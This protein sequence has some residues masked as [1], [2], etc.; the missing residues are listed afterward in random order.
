MPPA[1]RRKVILYV[2]AGGCTMMQCMSFMFRLYQCS[3]TDLTYTRNAYLTKGV[4][5]LSSGQNTR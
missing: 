3:Q 5:K 4:S 2:K 1:R